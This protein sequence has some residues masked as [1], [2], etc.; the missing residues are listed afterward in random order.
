MVE[1][2]PYLR[3]PA[4]Y[5]ANALTKAGRFVGH[6]TVPIRPSHYI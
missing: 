6:F 1:S 4:R 2:V 5:V 3:T